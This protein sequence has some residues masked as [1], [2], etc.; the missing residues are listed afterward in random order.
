MDARTFE[1]E[2]IV[3]I[4]NLETPP[5]SRPPTA[6][7]R[8][9]SPSYTRPPPSDIPLPP[10][11]RIMLFSGALEETF[12]IPSADS[13][14]RR[15]RTAS[16]RYRARD[17]TADEDG[18]GIVV[19]P[20]L[21]DREVDDDVR[22]LFQGRHALRTHALGDDPENTA[23]TLRDEDREDE[24]DVDELESD[25]L[26]SYNPSRAPSPAPA[27]VSASLSSPSTQSLR[28]GPALPIVIQPGS[29]H[30]VSRRG[31][32]LERRES[33]GPYMTRRGSSTALRRRRRQ[34]ESEAEVDIAGTCFD[35]SG[36]Y[37]YVASVKGISEW[38]VRGAEQSWWSSTSWA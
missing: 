32:L 18:E 37:I 11:P 21:G 13:T 4:P 20:P 25:C 1:T 19:I 29:R 14:G 23:E 27:P 33:S 30:E 8:S 31:S 17:W 22:R 35:P 15:R 9:T 16:Q 5:S 10:P 38:K 7:Q 3:R 28:G 2:E 24:M 26:S 36:E 6:R 34:T 12:R